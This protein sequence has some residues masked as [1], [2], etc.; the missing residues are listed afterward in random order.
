MSMAIV[1]EFLTTAEVAKIL[2]VTDGRVRQFHREERLK[3]AAKVGI[4]LLFDRE[5]VEEFSR[6]PRND[7]RP[8]ASDSASQKKSKRVR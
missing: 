8:P 5:S 2:G 7:G 1:G 4:Q 3:S 6:I